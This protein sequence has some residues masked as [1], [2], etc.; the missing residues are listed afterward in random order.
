MKTQ[1]TGLFLSRL[2]NRIRIERT[3][4]LRLRLIK[5]QFV[6]NILFFLFICLDGV[7]MVNS[8]LE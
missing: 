2:R 7:M 1:L 4:S 8:L 3:S 6:S 5:K